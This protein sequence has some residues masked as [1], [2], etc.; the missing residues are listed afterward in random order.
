[1]KICRCGATAARSTSVRRLPTP[2]TSSGWSIVPL[3][4]NILPS[5]ASA[6]HCICSLT[7]SSC[8][9]GEMVTFHRGRFFLQ[10]DG[11]RRYDHLG[12][13]TI[14]Q[15]Y[16]QCFLDVIRLLAMVEWMQFETQNKQSISYLEFY[17]QTIWPVKHFD[18]KKCLQII[19][20]AKNCPISRPNLFIDN[21]VRWVEERTN[22]IVMTF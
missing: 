9:E 15:K 13:N 7:R 17:C 19:C 12:E 5:L 4:I 3:F 6:I 2:P 18:C 1:M 20:V 21:L 14:T 8:S 22:I 16:F 11:L 10:L